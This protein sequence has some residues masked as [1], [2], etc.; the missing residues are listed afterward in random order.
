MP[1]NVPLPWWVPF[2]AAPV[3]TVKLTLD[4]PEL[5]S[6]LRA[7]SRGYQGERGAGGEL[8]GLGTGWRVFNDVDLDRENSDHV[9]VGSSGVYTIE[10]KNYA[11]SVAATPGGLHTHG[12]RNDKVVKQARRAS[13]KLRELLG[14]E[15]RPV[16]A[17]VHPFEGGAVG[18]LP[19]LHVKD[20]VT[21]L[22]AQSGTLTY[23][24]AQRVCAILETR[25][26]SAKLRP[27][28]M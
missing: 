26:R 14:T 10:V 11:G 1:H 4:D 16:L 22:Q 19:V 8:E 18:N 20:L 6:Q 12:K 5:R 2:V 25:V 21:F 13:H 9:V 27:R 15:V 24:D 23:P 3:I 7:T 28:C 17:F